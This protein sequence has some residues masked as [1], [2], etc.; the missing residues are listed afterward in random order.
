[1]GKH[2]KDSPVIIKRGK[3]K[4]D[5]IAGTTEILLLKLWIVNITDFLLDLVYTEENISFWLFS[6]YSCNLG[7]S[8]VYDILHLIPETFIVPA[9]VLWSVSSKL[10]IY[11]LFYAKD[12]VSL[13]I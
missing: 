6:Q 3:E 13:K 9:L 5:S 4:K 11:A 10:F 1:M 12:L 7:L 8:S 2:C